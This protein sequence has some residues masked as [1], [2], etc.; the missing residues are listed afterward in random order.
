VQEIHRPVWNAEISHDLHRNFIEISSFHRKITGTRPFK[1]ALSEVGAFAEVLQSQDVLEKLWDEK[2]LGLCAYWCQEDR[3]GAMCKVARL[4]AVAHA[5]V[6][7][8]K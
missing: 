3:V 8:H 2:I 5:A 6:S 7:D 1:Q 4:V